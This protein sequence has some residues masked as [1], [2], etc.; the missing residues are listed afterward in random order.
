MSVV[1]IEE[2]GSIH[3]DRL[4]K[5]LAG[6]PGGVWKA[7]YS[8]LKRAG[9][10]AKTRAGQFAAEEYTITKGTFMKN[11]NMKTDISGH[12]ESIV[13]MNIR[14][15]GNVLP[16][17]A[18]HTRYSRDGL[19]TTQVKRNGGAA[20]LQHAFAERVFGPVAVFERVGAP[21]F[22]VEQKFGPST[23]HMMENEEVVK[24]MDETI[25]ETYDKRME[26]EMMRVLNGW[27]G[28]S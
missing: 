24:R 7:S 23:A 2:V 1:R 22:P 28:R 18:F 13:S 12:S 19:L 10:T 6:I 20:T 3:L 11:V 9:E 27:G 8:A 16:L 4:N 15:G 17:L 26:H 14:Y 21:R 25:R 5:L